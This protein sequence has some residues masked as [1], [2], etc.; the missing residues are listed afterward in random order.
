MKNLDTNELKIRDLVVINQKRRT[1]Y[2]LVL[3]QIIRAF[4]VT[5]SQI[6]HAGPEITRF[7]IIIA[8]RKQDDGFYISKERVSLTMLKGLV[9]RT[10]HSCLMLVDS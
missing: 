7:E 9:T 1:F 2:F 6:G 5:H 3:V 10:V 8:I 4:K